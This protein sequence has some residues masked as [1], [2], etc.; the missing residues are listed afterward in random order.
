MAEGND[1]M[2]AGLGDLLRYTHATSLVGDILKIRVQTGMM[3]IFEQTP[4]CQQ[5]PTK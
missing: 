5:S 1:R 3:L 2:P 4:Y